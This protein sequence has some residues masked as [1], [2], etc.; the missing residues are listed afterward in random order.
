VAGYGCIAGSVIMNR[1]AINTYN[2]IED[3]VYFDEINEAYGKSL[4]QDNVS[5]ILSYTAIG[6]W[7]ADFI[8]TLVVTSDLNRPSYSSQ[9]RGL[10]LGSNIDPV[11]NAPLVSIVY[12]F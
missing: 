6:I 2:G 3:L 9:S 7:V 11:S 8:W 1:Q 5:E 4:T 10:S 12:S